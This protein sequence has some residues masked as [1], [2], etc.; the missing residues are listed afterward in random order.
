MLHRT[1][2]LPMAYRSVASNPIE[3]KRAWR[4]KVNNSNHSD[5]PDNAQ[6]VPTPRLPPSLNGAMATQTFKSGLGRDYTWR[7]VVKSPATLSYH[8]N[9][10]ASQGVVVSID[11]KLLHPTRVLRDT[12]AN[13]MIVS[14][15]WL[16]E[17][18]ITGIPR[19]EQSVKTS[20]G[21]NGTMVGKLPLGRMRLILCKST[22]FETVTEHKYMLSSG[23]S[24]LYQVLCGM[25]D[26][27]RINGRV[28]PAEQCMEFCPRFQEDGDVS[29]VG[30]VPMKTIHPY[31]ECRHSQQRMPR[32]FLADTAS[33]YTALVTSVPAHRPA[34][35]HACPPWHSDVL[36]FVHEG[37]HGCLA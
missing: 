20:T 16:L 34:C 37:W 18:G 2:E 29:F 28:L 15:E 9:K 17:N 8:E 3:N 22:P 33:Q 27:N 25:D 13:C 35:M 14:R 36:D 6:A 10:R 11:G 12:A 19:G 5:V 26:M 23:T 7:D 1:L 32:P 31:H 30:R 21:G 4:E 24:S